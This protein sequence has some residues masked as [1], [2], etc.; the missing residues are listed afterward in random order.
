MTNRLKV[1]LDICQE[2]N[3]VCI[4]HPDGE[5]LVAHRP[6][7]NNWP[8]YQELRQFLL[9]TLEIHSCQGIDLAGEATGPFWFHT[10]RL[11][12]QDPLLADR[13]LHLYLFNPKLVHGFRQALPPEDKDDIKDPQLIANYLRFSHPQHPWHYQSKYLALQRLTRHH[14]HL[15]HTL[16]REK[17]YFLSLLYLKASEYGHLKPFSDLLGKTST[18]ILQNYATIGE[19]A[20]IPLDELTELLDRLGKRRFPDPADNARKLLQVARDSYPMPAELLVPIN[21]ALHQ[22]L[23]EIVCLEKLLAASRQNLA[24]A[25]QDFPTAQALQAWNGLGPVCTGGIIAEIQDPQRFVEGLKYDRKSKTMRP[26]TVWDGQAALAK[27]AGLWWPQKQS[28]NLAAE[29]R[30]LCTQ[31]NVYLRYYLIEAANSLRR[32]TAEYAAYYER[33]YAESRKHHHW[34][35]LVLTARKLIRPIFMLL[36]K[37]VADWY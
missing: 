12:A 17:T 33:K 22:L 36:M 10:F 9:A 32:H 1:G 28:G 14:C 19:L 2:R 34:R 11:L 8:G 24:A 30:H 3:D 29:E 5:I 15:A 21:F 16:A 4:Q 6:F 23:E 20:A 13:D 26:K 25:L 37:P 7:P 31:G 18:T 35:A 27:F